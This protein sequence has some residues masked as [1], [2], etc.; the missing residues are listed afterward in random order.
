[1]GQL[2]GSALYLIAAGLLVLGIGQGIETVTH[3][4]LVGLLIGAIALWWWQQ[5]TPASSPSP[6]PSR[7]YVQHLI[8][9][10]QRDI[11]KLRQVEDQARWTERLG[12]IEQDLSEER[13]RVA[14]LG[15]AGVGKTALVRAIAQQRPTASPN[16]FEWHLLSHPTRRVRFVEGLTAA[17]AD[18]VLYVTDGLLQDQELAHLFQIQTQRLLVIMNKQDMH[19]PGDRHTLQEQLRE[20]LRQWRSDVELYVTTAQ[21]RP[22]KVRQNE[23]QHHAERIWH[24]P[25]PPNLDALPQRLVAIFAQEWQSLHYA[26]LVRRLQ[27]DRDTLIDQLFCE[28]HREAQAIIRRHQ[29]LTA[30]T[31]FANPITALDLVANTALN[32]QMLVELS[33]LYGQPLTLIKAT[34]IAR[35]L[36]QNLLQM[37]C[38][39]VA[40]QAIALGLK[41]NAATYA[42]GGSVQAIGAA[43]LCHLA[44]EGFITALEAGL[45]ADDINA[46][47]AFCRDS[48][49]RS[50]GRGFFQNLLGDWLKVATTG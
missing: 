28:R 22:L 17:E 48:F 27:R 47:Q 18:L 29:W 15:R 31:M 11:P 37:G 41:T 49:G 32:A 12:Q 8:Q 45:K 33:H 23:T 7:S 38:V 40:T 26:G 39:E 24:E 25:Q 13:L 35:A 46:L 2:K 19:L 20:R 21:P 34:P 44:G 6:V 3:S 42:V 9:Q 5:A 43:Y 50:Q 4:P 30:T 36:L 1:M 16:P 14:V 10:I